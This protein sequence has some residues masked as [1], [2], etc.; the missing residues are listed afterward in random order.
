VIKKDEG[1]FAEPRITVSTPFCS[2]LDCIAHALQLGPLTLMQK[3]NPGR[4]N[5]RGFSD[6]RLMSGGTSPTLLRVS[7]REPS[8]N[9][10]D[11][12]LRGLLH[13]FFGASLLSRHKSGIIHRSIVARHPTEPAP[14]SR[15][16]YRY[17]AGSLSWDEGRIV[18]LKT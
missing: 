14:P 1:R 16:A 15:R 5:C 18:T 4:G 8:S 9:R 6:W 13:Q 10:R 3:R 17:P 7:K 12:I 11:R 2:R